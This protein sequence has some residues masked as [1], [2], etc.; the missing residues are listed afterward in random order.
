MV[1]KLKTPI[2]AAV[3]LKENFKE[4]IG[5]KEIKPE[6]LKFT[7]E[8]PNQNNIIVWATKID[9]ESYASV[10]PDRQPL[11]LLAKDLLEW[12][13]YYGERLDLLTTILFIRG[14]AYLDVLEIPDSKTAEEILRKEFH[15]Q[16]S[17][18][19]IHCFHWEK[20][21][22]NRKTLQYFWAA[23]INLN[24]YAAIG[25]FSGETVA[26]RND[27][28]LQTIFRTDDKIANGY[29]LIDNGGV[30]RLER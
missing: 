30:L 26:L 19:L 2:S 6:L 22:S 20:G 10:T 11:I 21:A 23:R 14:Q 9:D 17:I 5:K 3:F 27:A 24:C 29:V 25:A 15:I 12:H 1:Q 13:P 16:T 28:D 7:S 4:L 8:K 18:S